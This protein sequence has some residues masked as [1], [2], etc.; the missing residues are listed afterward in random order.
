M[1][2]CLLKNF[3]CRRCFFIFY[4]ATYQI[5]R[6]QEFIC[7]FAKTFIFVQYFGIHSPHETII[8]SICKQPYQFF[9]FWINCLP[10]ER[11]T[12]ILREVL[13]II[14]QNHQVIFAYF[15]IGGIN[16]GQLDLAFIKRLVCQP[17]I[18]PHRLDIY[19]IKF[20][21]IFPAILTLYE[22]IA[23]SRLDLRMRFQI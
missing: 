7:N 4:S 17:V 22:L 14:I 16:I 11:N 10:H 1:P 13:L 15:A 21:K 20:C 6:F 9:C 5:I 19:V 23:H 18:D 2:K 8:N 12:H 3:I